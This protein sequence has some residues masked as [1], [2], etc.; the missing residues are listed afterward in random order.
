[1]PEEMKGSKCCRCGEDF[2][3]HE[4]AGARSPEEADAQPVP[5]D[6]SVCGACGAILQ[7]TLEGTKEVGAEALPERERLMAMAI[8]AMIAIRKQGFVPPEMD[9]HCPNCKEALNSPE[10]LNGNSAPRGPKPGD[11]AICY[12][13]DMPAV[14]DMQMHL[15][16]FK[17]ENLPEEAQGLLKKALEQVGAR[18]GRTKN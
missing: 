12:S 16:A 8:S 9:T 1:M 7:F 6:F 5:G 15:R 11:V 13:C 17:P 14:F 3:Q 2:T 4:V 10:Y 18:F